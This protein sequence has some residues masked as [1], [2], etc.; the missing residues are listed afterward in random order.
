MPK[1]ASAANRVA[2]PSTSKTGKE[3]LGESGEM[4]G[5]HWVDQRQFV[6]GAE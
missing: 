2:R 1:S 4:G 3:M 5:D 6:F